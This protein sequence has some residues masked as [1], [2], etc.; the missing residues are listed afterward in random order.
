MSGVRAQLGRGNHDRPQ[1]S[2]TEG[3]PW[4]PRTGRHLSLVLVLNLVHSELDDGVD[5]VLE[6]CDP[7]HHP[8]LVP[9]GAPDSPGDDA[10]QVVP[11]ILLL[12]GHGTTRVPL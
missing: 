5:P 3:E 7:C 2:L 6:V 12:H 8:R 1:S 11:P 10:R 4:T 9:L